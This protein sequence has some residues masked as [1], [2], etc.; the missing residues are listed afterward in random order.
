[1][2]KVYTEGEVIGKANVYI[3]AMDNNY[4]Y[5]YLA[6]DDGTQVGHEL[7]TGLTVEE[8]EQLRANCDPAFKKEL[9]KQK[10]EDL[11]KELESI[12]D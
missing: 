12:K 1:M 10:I 4:G 8:V 2:S 3:K 11:Q 5:Y 7:A 6:I 9:I